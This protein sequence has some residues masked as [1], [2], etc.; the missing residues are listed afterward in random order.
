MHTSMK[1]HSSVNI[2]L[3]KGYND[4]YTYHSR[5]YG[6]EEKNLNFVIW[7]VAKCEHSDGLQD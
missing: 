1:Y 5:H 2:K 3:G 7:V 6:Y 4:G